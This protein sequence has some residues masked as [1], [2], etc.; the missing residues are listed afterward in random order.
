MTPKRLT[1]EECPT[2]RLFVEPGLLKQMIEVCVQEILEEEVSRH[3]GAGPYER[4]AARQGR[5][6]GAKPRTMKTAV[7][8]L[9][10]RL[11]QVR[12]GGF[13]TQ[14]FD[15]WQ[16]SDKALVAAMQEMVVS[17]VSTRAVSGVLEEMGG[18]EVSAATVS[19]T[20]AE[21]DEQIAAFFSRPLGGREYLYLIVDARYEKVRRNGRVVSQAVL[22]A[23]GITREGRREL[24][25]LTMGDSES[26]DTWSEVFSGLKSRGLKGVELLVS[27]AHKGIIAAMDKHLQGVAWQRCKVHL[28]R[29]MLKKVSYR[30]D[31]ELA[32]DLRS[33]YASSERRQCLA[34]AEQVATKWETKAPKLSEALRAGVE[35]TL[36]VLELPPQLARRL[37]S[38]NMLERAM[39]EIKKRTRQVNSF[40]NEASCRRLIGAVLLEMQDRWDVETQR[41][42]I[43]EQF[44][45]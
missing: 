33:I 22:I 15:R 2:P 31:K 18:F 16:R 29:E 42:I 3:L 34:V 24:L 41:Y 44:P 4:S 38:T 25:S 43:P 19:R 17:G 20:M 36:T 7:G 6:N 8:Q 11:P 21:L 39:K 23:A 35:A 5:R 10:L 37:N 26:F 30:D 28:M 9:E 12:E 40:P 13:R 45:F 32:A 1:T 27:D 14:L